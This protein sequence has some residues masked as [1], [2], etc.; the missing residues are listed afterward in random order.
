[1]SDTLVILVIGLG[2]VLLAMVPFYRRQRNVERVTAEAEELARRYGLH[3]P[4]SLHPV[5]DVGACIGTGNCVS[6]CPEGDVLGMRHGQAFTVSPARCI[7]HGVCERACPTEA[8][9][10]VF[11]SAKRGVEI[12]R[13]KQNF[14]TNVPG[15]YIIGELGGMGLIRNAFEQG[16]QCIEGI[17][18]A[19]RG[20]ANALDVAIVGCGPAGLSASLHALH[21]DL[22]FVTLE[23][24]DIGGTV[25]YYPRKKIVMTSSVK[26]PG[27]GKL[28]FREIAKEE[29]IG[30]WEDI[31]RRTDLHVETGV[32]VSNVAREPDGCFTVTSATG[33]YR[34]RRVI[35]AIGRRGVPR[36]LNVPGEDLPKVIYSLREP[37]AYQKD[38]ILVVGG[39]DSA[40]E[41]AMALAD[42]PGNQVTI[43]YRG[44]QFSRI[45][46]GNLTRIEDA[47]GRNRVRVLWK[48]QVVAIDQQSVTCRN[49]RTE[50][51]PNDVVAI[52][53]GGELPLKFLESCGVQIDRKFGEP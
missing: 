53:A 9:Q 27:Y 29:L 16:R 48:T 32:T 8:I 39:G 12:P 6:A 45:K 38:R 11:G 40:I 44:E 17:A 21:H 25:R 18:A 7:G 15:L 24:E 3:E 47:I 19:G 35:L 30:I 4:V 37:E 34:A 41:A 51:L 13:I 26:V 42:Q 20:P 10:L 23:K 14:E 2:L 49:G 33:S 31:V 52:F 28:S 22:R 1:M 43:S 46:P 36:K 5:V 50:T